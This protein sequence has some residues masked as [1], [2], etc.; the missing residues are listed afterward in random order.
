MG[1]KNILFHSFDQESHT[2]DKVSWRGGDDVSGA[3]ALELESSGEAAAFEDE[4]R[5]VS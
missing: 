2:L 5:N 4:E 1:G 3:A